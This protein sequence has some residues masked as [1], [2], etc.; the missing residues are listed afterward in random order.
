M[1]LTRRKY[2]IPNLQYLI[3]HTTPIFLTFFIIIDTSL[4]LV[5]YLP[6]FE[7]TIGWTQIYADFH[8]SIRANPANQCHPRS[9]LQAGQMIRKRILE[10]LKRRKQATVGEL[11]RQL[12]MAPVSVRYHLDI[13]Q[14][15]NL[16]EVGKVQRE[17]SVGRPKQVYTLTGDADEYFPDNFAG[18]TSGLVR[19]MKSLLPSEQVQSAFCCLAREMAQELNAASSPDD[20]LSQRMG[21]VVDFLNERGYFA[22]WEEEANGQSVLLHTSNCP[23]AGVAEHHRE[24]CAMDLELMQNL[25]GQACERVF[26]LAEDGNACTY[27]FLLNEGW[28]A[29][30]WDGEGVLEPVGSKIELSY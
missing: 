1:A 18:L 6:L 29:E 15:D 27:R 26:S 7:K 17:G 11:A 16:I 25:T 19:Q 22:R 10:I 3:S 5:L 4:A 14:G 21:R 2:P 30:G 20:N 12:D 9:I 13:L 23:Y 24:L 28:D 8:A